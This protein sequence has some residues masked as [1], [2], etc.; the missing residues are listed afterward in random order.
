MITNGVLEPG[1]DETVDG[2]RD[3]A[4]LIEGR[5]SRSTAIP[6]VRRSNVSLVD[7]PGDSH[8]TPNATKGRHIT[9]E[10]KSLS[11]SV[12]TDDESDY[13][14]SDIE[15]FSFDAPEWMRVNSKLRDA[16]MKEPGWSRTIRLLSGDT[17]GATGRLRRT[18]AGYALRQQ[19]L[20]KIISSEGSQRLALVVPHSLRAEVLH[21]AHDSRVGGH[22]GTSRTFGRLRSQYF[23]KEMR[24]DIRRYVGSCVTCGM[25]KARTSRPMGHLLPLASSTIPFEKVAID[26]FGSIQNSPDGKKY[27]FV[28]IDYCTRWVTA[29][30]TEAP[31]AADAANF[32]RRIILDHHP[33]EVLSDNGSEFANV[34]TDLLKSFGILHRHSTPRHP[35]GNGSVERANKTI[36]QILRTIM[37]E[38]DHSD[39][40]DCLPFA[41][42]AY[43]TTIH[44]V[45]RFTPHFLLFGY[46][47]RRPPLLGETSAPQIPLKPKDVTEARREAAERTEAH[48]RREKERYD[49]RRRPAML[50]VG[51]LVMVETSLHKPGISIRFAPRRTGPFEVTRVYDNNTVEV[52]GESPATMRV[53]V[54]RCLKIMRRP[55]Y[56]HF[57]DGLTDT[58]DAV[59]R[60]PGSTSTGGE[61]SQRDAN[62]AESDFWEQS[63]AA[64]IEGR[65][66][67]SAPLEDD[68]D[69][70][71]E[72]LQPLRRS[73]RASKRPERLIEVMT[74]DVADENLQ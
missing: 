45:T 37:V 32:M 71:I 31:K 59:A 40:V 67:S 56:L 17:K 48:R 62:P 22:L 20:H 18:A 35:K 41:V 63:G 8:R 53:N 57:D 46:E 36:S 42:Q 11:T 19:L 64:P 58:V 34:F 28:A 72:A 73:H 69:T 7:G 10:N 13:S 55:S 16:Q 61:G 27:V 15:D 3:E 25:F 26:K 4:N 1:S 5:Q 68:E 24:D 2:H 29:E 52:K 33:A 74:V 23:W 44:D 65:Q 54:E 30:A 47:P 70:G 43:N 51:D 6:L 9:W 49:K 60:G 12:T 66:S 21:R 14:D 39:W 50:I 38:K